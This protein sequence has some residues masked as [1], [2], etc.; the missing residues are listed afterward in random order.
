MNF[1]NLSPVQKKWAVR[2]I[3]VLV[4]S[5]LAIPVYLKKSN[6]DQTTEKKKVVMV[7]DKETF[8]KSLLA[9][10]KGELED[11]KTNNELFKKEIRE[12][13]KTT[14]TNSHSELQKY[15][16]NLSKSS[17]EQIKL[18][19]E[20]T[21]KE[22]IEAITGEK[23][24]AIAKKGGLKGMLAADKAGNK[25]FEEPN[26][27]RRANDKIGGL[28]P[29]DTAGI[30][31]IKPTTDDKNA[32]A[33]ENQKNKKKNY[34]TAYLPPSFTEASLLSGVVAPT[35]DISNKKP[36]PMI[37]RIKDLAVL[38]NEYKEDLKGCFVIAEG[39]A[40]LS[41]ERVE[42]RLVTLSCISKDGR[43]LIDQKVKGWVVD[44]DG[45]AGMRGLV[46]AK[47]GAHVAR[48]AIAG[49]MRGFGEAFQESTYMVTNSIY[50]TQKTMKN[51]DPSSLAKAGVGGGI[52]AV[53]EDLE[54]FYLHLAE[55]TLPCVEVGPAKDIT[56]VFSEGVDLEIKKRKT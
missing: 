1:S 15:K 27:K 43:S 25:I 52:V 28:A 14:A 29:A 19:E 30:A 51:T 8:E 21:Q 3:A 54:K 11:I 5:I 39:Q 40:D 20:K 49:L 6:R 7:T 12:L 17:A 56:I 22:I 4:I 16:E 13:M 53:A 32:R 26:D 42:A 36:I 9:Q 47:F 41:Q 37:I 2:G 45:R 33:K 31:E 23:A 44:A 46:V 35:S 24:E 34:P 48:V 50:G 10:T 18:Q 38:P 55:Q